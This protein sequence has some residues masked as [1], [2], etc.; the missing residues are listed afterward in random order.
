MVIVTDLCQPMTS[1]LTL[2]VHW[3]VC[4][5]L[6]RVTSVQ[7]RHSVRA[8]SNAPIFTIIYAI[9]L[10]PICT[11]SIDITQNTVPSTCA[12]LASFHDPY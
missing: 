11:R 8:P 5:K 1:D 12:I 7:L 9:V 3:S 4:Q 6:N 2:L 10:Y